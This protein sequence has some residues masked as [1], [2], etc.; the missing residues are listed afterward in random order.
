MLSTFL[1][2]SLLHHFG[3]FLLKTTFKG[4]KELRY[5]G[6]FSHGKEIGL[7]KFYQYLNEKSILSATKKFNDSNSVAEVRF[8]NPSGSIIS[9]GK[10]NGKKYV[11]EWNYYHKNSVKIMRIERYDAY[12]LQQGE[13]KVYYKNGQLA[14][15]SNYKDDKLDGE[16]LWFNQNGV[17]IKKF[18]Y[19]EGLLQGPSKIYSNDGN[20]IV[21]GQYKG[22][23][24]HGIWLYYEEGKLLKQKD[25]T[26]RSKNPYI[27]KAP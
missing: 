18:T 4:T 16:S 25:F 3:H 13:F 14:E 19:K 5:E 26:K 27:K 21:E 24:K 9:Q 1:C 6:Q 8:Y 22:D 17:I 23:K 11:G 2:L 20:L 7:F 15:K 12:G 10:M